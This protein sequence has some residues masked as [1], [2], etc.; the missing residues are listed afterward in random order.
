M[1]GGRRDLKD[2]GR[3]EGEN[4]QNISCTIKLSIESISHY[5]FIKTTLWW[6]VQDIFWLKSWLLVVVAIRD[7]IL[8]YYTYTL[9]KKTRLLAQ[10]WQTPYPPKTRLYIP[11]V[12]PF[13]G[14]PLMIFTSK[15]NRWRIKKDLWREV[16]SCA[17]STKHLVLVRLERF[18]NPI[19]AKWVTFVG[20]LCEN[21]V[22]N[23]VHICS[24]LIV[25]SC[26][27]NLFHSK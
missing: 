21:L 6:Q 22:P 2:N 7:E 1:C 5:D 27:Q 23:L 14:K 24:F 13:P 8:G 10:Y 19:P 26:Q 3:Q 20:I 25:P 9:I 15:C 12:W 4:T 11:L 17:A 18:I 16:Y